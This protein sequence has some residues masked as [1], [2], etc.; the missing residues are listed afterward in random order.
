VF[1]F[2]H[3][4][5]GCSQFSELARALA[6]RA[7]IW[8][9]N[10]PGRQAR[11]DEAPPR[12]LVALVERLAAELLELGERPYGLIGYCGGALLAFLVA[13]A[14]REH[15]APPPL[16]LVVVSSEAPDIALRPMGWD[17][18]PSHQLWDRLIRDGGISAELAADPRMR[19]VAEP[20]VRADFA[21]LES[22]VHTDAPP[23]S[24]PITVCYGSGER[25]RRGALLGWRRQTVA[26]LALRPL[27]GG[28]WLLDH[29][30]T[31]LAAVVAEAMQPLRGQDAG[32]PV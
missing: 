16:G 22:Y 7:A 11:L 17:R 14:L 9:A 23:L 26:P 30:V 10:L 5:A 19:R 32:D 20:A 24:C 13:R 1:A 29:A 31:G 4:G 8:A 25:I 15:G 28:H 18:L 3:V 6:P 12:D 2:P 21:L 27:E